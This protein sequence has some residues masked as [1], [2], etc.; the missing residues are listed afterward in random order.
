MSNAGKHAPNRAAPHAWPGRGS[1]AAMPARLG[2][3]IGAEDWC[4][5]FFQRCG[6]TFRESQMATMLGL[7][8]DQMKRLGVTSAAAYY[9]LLSDAADGSQEWDDLLAGVLNH[10]TSFFRHPASFDV[11]HA[12]I[13][14]ELIA[15]R[16][17]G[18]RV[19]FW[20]AGCS[21][22]QETYSLAMVAMAEEDLAGD[23]IVWGSDLSR[24]V[25]E[26]ARRGR[27]GPRALVG[28]SPAF[29]NR[30]LREVPNERGG[31][32]YEIVSELRERVRFMSMNL[33]STS[34]FGPRH[35]VIFCHNVLIY[36]APSAASRLIAALAL[37][38]RPG[39]YLL[40]G[41]GEGPTEQPPGLEPLHVPGVRGFKRTHQAATERRP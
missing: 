13:L 12:R 33:F 39:G 21:T 16:P 41:P 40:L 24:R 32:D 26:I 38:L 22:G 7:I 4:A 27:Y 5:L 17:R 19:S 14:P 8:E 20:S 30:F 10:E 35:D 23:F 29:R 2:D 1:G 9:A 34:D 31:V 37:R 28:L 6:L 3:L 18:G 25:I 11:L 15:R 36:L